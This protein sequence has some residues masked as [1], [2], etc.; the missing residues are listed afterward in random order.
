ML[1][2]LFCGV[3][4]F[5]L[6]IAGGV[7]AAGDAAIFNE[8]VGR[9]HPVKPAAIMNYEVSYSLLHIRLKR[10]AGATIKASEGVWLSHVSNT[11]IPACII[12]FQVATPEARDGSIAL[13]KRTVCVLTLP[14]LKIIRYVKKN[15]EVIRPFFSRER[16][17][18]Y[19]EVYDFESG[20]LAYHRYDHISG[21]EA[22]NLVNMADLAKQGAEVSDVLQTLFAS[23]HELPVVGHPHANTVHF[24]VEGTI[25]TFELRMMKGK[26]MASVLGRKIVALYA[27]V[28][29]VAGSDGRSESFSM[30]CLPF[31]D[32]ARETQDPA[33]KQLAEISLECSMVPLSG[34][35]ALF[36]GALDCVLTH[37]QVLPV[38]RD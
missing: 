1:G 15:D 32:F 30:W 5:V 6:F 9:F 38:E 19:S 20:A 8:V 11:P 37:V 7:H 35:Y 31:R 28:Q 14:D 25:R 34:E 12:D 23:Y 26:T 24:N 29:P 4:L 33:L 21:T 36:L 27:D 3:A 2:Q 13:F 10:V 22:T 18:N 17:M 16:R